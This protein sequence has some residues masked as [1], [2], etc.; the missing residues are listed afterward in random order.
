MASRV[1]LLAE[2]ADTRLHFL[3]DVRFRYSDLG[4]GLLGLALATRAGTDYAT[5]VAEN[6]CKPLG[7]TRTSLSEPVVQ[8]HTRRGRPIP[9]WNM[10]ALAWAGGLRSTAAADDPSD[11]P[12][13]SLAP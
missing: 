5:F 8:G 2:L 3:P 13:G 1:G 7:M 10:A 4:A 11:P 6:V 9:P 12:T